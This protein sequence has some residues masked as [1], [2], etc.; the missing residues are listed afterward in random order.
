VELED[1]IRTEGSKSSNART[2]LTVWLFFGTSAALS[3]TVWLLPVQQGRVIYLTFLQW[4]MEWPLIL[5]VGNCLPGILALVWA[6]FLGK[7]QLGRILHS[8]LAW[9]TP[10]RWYVLSIILPLGVFLISSSIV[11]VYFPSKRGWPPVSPLFEG[12]LTLPFG[13][14]WEEIAWRAFALRRLQSRYSRLT[15]SLIVG[16]YWA[17]WHIPL[18]YLTLGYVTVTLLLIMCINL[19]AWSVIFASLY[20]R[21][22]ESLPVVILLHAVYMAAQNEAFAAVSYSNIHLIPVSAVLS[23]C[24]AIVVTRCDKRQKTHEDMSLLVR[25]HGESDR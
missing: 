3:W 24:L 1:H 10:L 19:I 5:V 8:L 15:S 22:M 4:R 23:L 20:N 21:S 7:H 13:P 6:L 11:V 17:V 14:L 12:L 16:V 18:W 9:R 25:R 2:L